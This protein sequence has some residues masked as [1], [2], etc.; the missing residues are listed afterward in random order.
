MASEVASTALPGVSEGAAFCLESTGPQ[1]GFDKTRS[2]LVGWRGARLA[3]LGMGRCAFGLLSTA[4]GSLGRPLWSRRQ[5]FDVLELASL[6]DRPVGAGLFRA[7]FGCS[8]ASR[9]PLSFAAARS[10]HRGC[11]FPPRGSPGGHPSLCVFASER[12]IHPHGAPAGA[13]PVRRAG[14]HAPSTVP[15]LG[16]YSLGGCLL[17]GKVGWLEARGGAAPKSRPQERGAEG[18][19]ARSAPSG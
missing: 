7:W 5:L 13:L 16:S 3:W 11:P 18:G 12:R 9:G 1:G 19:G 14:R 17:P 8:G 6:W 15:W 2:R 10:K 4:R